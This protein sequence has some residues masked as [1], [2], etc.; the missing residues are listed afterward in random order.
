[1]PYDKETEVAVDLA[2]LMAQSVPKPPSCNMSFT[3]LCLKKGS[4]GTVA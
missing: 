2:V 4:C 3:W 1:M